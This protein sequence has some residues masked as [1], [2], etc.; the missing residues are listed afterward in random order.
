VVDKVR[1]EK[2]WY[3]NVEIKIN[4]TWMAVC[5]TKS[6]HFQ[7][8]IVCNHFNM[9]YQSS[10]LHSPNGKE[11]GFVNNLYCDSNLALDMR[12]CNYNNLS[13]SSVCNDYVLQVQCKRPYWSGVHLAMTNSK[14]KLCHLEIHEAGYNYRRDLSITAAALRVDFDQHVISNIFVKNSAYVGVHVMYSNPFKNV[15][16]LSDS[17]IEGSESNG[18]QIGFSY[19]V[20]N[21]VNISD[22]K[23]RGLFSRTFWNDLDLDARRMSDPRFIHY[24]SYCNETSIFI[25]EGDTMYLVFSPFKGTTSTCVQELYT[26]NKSNIAVQIIYHNHYRYSTHAE[27]SSGNKQWN[28]DALSWEQRPVLYANHS[29]IRF[30]FVEYRSHKSLVVHL[31]AFTVNNGE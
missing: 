2:E 21:R 1:L 23:G 20:I 19:S 18:V 3:G 5:M 27:I 12:S 31:L 15:P 28:L 17:L 10:S 8:Q 26:V 7:S 4:N 24:S 30:R 6:Y 25:K 22:C 14:S 11:H 16:T 9:E 29:R 13:Y